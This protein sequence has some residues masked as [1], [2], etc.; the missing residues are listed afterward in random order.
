M[1]GYI[2]FVYSQSNVLNQQLNKVNQ[3]LSQVKTALT[4]KEG[5][6]GQ[7][8]TQIDQLQQTVTEAQRNLDNKTQE[9]IDQTKKQTDLLSQYENFKA[10]LGTENASTFDALL[11]LSVGI[12]NKDLMRIPV[13]D[14][15]FNGPDTDG[16]GLSDIA[17]RAFGTDMTKKD[18]DG[19][20]HSDKVEILSGYS[21]LGA[22]RLSIDQKF[23]DQNRGKILLQVEGKGEAWYVN[24]KDGKRYFLGLPADALKA[25]QKIG[26]A[27]P[28]I[29]TPATSTAKALPV[30]NT[31]TKATST[32]N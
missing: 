28:V 17:E 18:T 16:D 5:E 6:V 19:D 2:L 21:P 26:Q 12:S 4:A 11:K 27:L 22:G 15:N 24:P 7:K 9:L 29:A 30:N 23:A 32:K 8:Q 10:E 20:S 13:A 14:Y 3:D 1:L 25:L 31:T